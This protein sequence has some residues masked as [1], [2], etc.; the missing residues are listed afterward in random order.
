MTTIRNSIPGYDSHRRM[1]SISLLV[2][3]T[4]EQ[5]V[6]PVTT[7]VVVLPLVFYHNFLIR[8]KR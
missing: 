2:K 3:K 6:K 7:Q 8:A 5:Y 1:Q 4:A